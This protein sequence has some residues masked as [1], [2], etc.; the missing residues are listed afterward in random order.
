MQTP[1]RKRF[2]IVGMAR[3]GTT[4]TLQALQGHPDVRTA[5]DEI[6]VDPFFT[7]G[8]GAFTVSGQNDWEREHGMGL[9]IDALSLIPGA[10][11]DPKL[12]GY[13]G[14]KAHPKSDRVRA[15]GLKVA[16][17]SALEA[18][19]LVDAMQEN[20]SLREVALIRVHRDD[21]VAQYASLVRAMRSGVWHSFFKTPASIEHPEGPFTIPAD[22]FEV[23][24]RDCVT[25]RAQLDRLKWTHPMLDVSYER[26]IEAKGIGAFGRVFEF[27]SLPAIEAV[28]IGSTKVAPPVAAFVTNWEQL[29]DIAAKLA[30]A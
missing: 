22:E 27:L 10:E 28:W 8:I 1:S 19:Q 25:V 15:N 4:V 9:L 2:V 13:G 20:E 5:M 18:R 21:L 3:S 24:C 30:A 23:Y 17:G 16:L 12:M 11:G 7:R 29:Y 26:D 14:T 6:R